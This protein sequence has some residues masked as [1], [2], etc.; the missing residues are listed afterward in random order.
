M[1]IAS[2]RQSGLHSCMI[3]NK[4]EVPAVIIGVCYCSQVMLANIR[5][6]IHVCQHNTHQVASVSQESRM[7][8]QGAYIRYLT[9]GKAY[10]Q[11]A[12]RLLTGARKNRY[13]QEG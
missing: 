10:S 4:P 3:T 6:R 7:R 5:V 2:L 13:V 1:K 8:A 11:I 9:K 12:M